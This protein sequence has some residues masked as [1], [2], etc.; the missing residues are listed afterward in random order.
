MSF[1]LR[2][3]RAADGNNGWFEREQAVGQTIQR[4]RPDLLGTQEG[5]FPQIE[6]LRAMLPEYASVA[7]ARD[8]GDRDGETCALFYRR[9]VLTLNRSGTFWF[10]ETPEVPGSRHW[11]RHHP[12]ICTW[13]EFVPIA[14]PE[15]VIIAYNVHL[16]HEAQIAREKS[17]SMIRER[18][19]QLPTHHSA[20]AMGDFNLEPDNRGYDIMTGGG[21]DAPIDTYGRMMLSED[22]S[23][24]FHDFTGRHD[25][26]RIDYIFV[27]PNLTLEH[28]SII[29]DSYEGRFPSDH[30][31]ILA[32][33]QI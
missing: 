12:R 27:T 15:T 24:T 29:H 33:V 21:A 2:N 7:V 13:G 31:P 18:M 10:S 6:A 26:G 22:D 1:N 14:N 20:V 3:M 9:D 4:Y 23:G 11:T 16:D 5:Y 8:D 25:M 28:A 32:T 17:C 19:S 30:Y